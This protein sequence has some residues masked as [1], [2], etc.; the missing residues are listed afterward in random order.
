[1]EDER[2]ETAR[3]IREFI[4]EH[5]LFGYGNEE[6]DDDASLLE[7]GIL[8]SLGILELISFIEDK[9]GIRV[10]D[11]EILPENLDSI[12]GISR[13]ILR[14]LAGPLAERLPK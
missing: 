13:F 12:G 9:F 14:K 11:E 3:R 7:H 6:F 10:S 5:Y 8:D 2:K 4:N 1:M